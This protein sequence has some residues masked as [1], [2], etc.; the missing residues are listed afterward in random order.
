[1]SERP[2][3]ETERKLYDLAYLHLEKEGNESRE[4]RL[5]DFARRLERERDAA[6][7]V[8]SELLDSQDAI[9]PPFSAGASAQTAWAER[10]HKARIAARA[11][12][13]AIEEGRK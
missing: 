4:G 10:K 1:M 9:F 6:V 13:H 7:E 2:T 5:A 11:T 3:P 12:L 8:L